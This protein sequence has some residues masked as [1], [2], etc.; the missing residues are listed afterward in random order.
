MAGDGLHHSEYDPTLAAMLLGEAAHLLRAIG[1]AADHAIL[2]GGMVP[3]LLVLDPGLGHPH[4]GTADLDLCLSLALVE[5]DTAE[6]ERIE[7]ALKSIGYEMTDQSFR[8]RR[9]AG[10]RPAVEFFCPAGEERPAGELFR[11]LAEVNP[12]AKRVMGPRLS[13]L[14]LSAGNAISSDVVPVTRD[15]ELPDAGGI[16]QWTFRVTGLIGFLVA[17][18]DALIRRNKNKDAYDIV[19]LLENWEGGPEGAGGSVSDSSLLGR[20]DVREAMTSLAREFSSIDRTGPRSYVA[21]MAAEAASADDR[22]RLARI[23]VGAVGEFLE[24]LL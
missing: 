18:V 23:A 17:K 16:I 9:N 3:G 5:A 13:A 8:W 11:P 12:I 4:V 21:F 2:I 15:V 7:T 22:A 24:S 20:D 6:Y 10:L 1:F 19:W 14:A